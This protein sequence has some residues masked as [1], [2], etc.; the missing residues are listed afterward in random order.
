MYH[1]H[2]CFYLLGKYNNGFEIIKNAIP[3]EHFTHEFCESDKLEKEFIN[4]ADV[5]IA[6][7]KD[8]DVKETLEI[9][10]SKKKETELIVLIE[11]H[12]SDLLIDYLSIIKD[13]WKMP[14]S[15]EEIKFRFLRWQ[16]TYKIG[17][18]YWQTSHL[19]ESTINNIPNLIWYKDKEGIHQKVNDSFCKTVNKTKTTNNAA[20]T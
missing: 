18:D 14:M 6:N 10:V 17:K 9:L 20:V 19:F 15:H 2:I 16:E 1:C 12:Q 7:L 13:V 5:I 4:Q 11:D 8:M 3:L